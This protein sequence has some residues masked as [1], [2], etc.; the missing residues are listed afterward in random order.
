M[1]PSLFPTQ[2][3]YTPTSARIIDQHLLEQKG[4][5]GDEL[6]E[7]AGLSAFLIFKHIYPKAS[8][9]SVVTGG[10]NNAGDGF[11]LARLAHKEGL[12][13]R[14]YPAI[15]PI[16]LRG[17]AANAFNKFIA[18]GGQILSFVPQDFEGTEILIDAIFGS[19]LNRV[20]DEPISSI[21]NAINRYR[22]NCSKAQS[23][24]RA[25][26]SLDIPSGL[27]GATGSI[28]GV[29][30]KAD[31]TIS[32]ITQKQGLYTGEGPQNSGEIYLSR[33]LDNDSE[34]PSA[35]R[36]TAKIYRPPPLILPVR[37]RTAHK[38][39]FGHV[40]VIGG[41]EGMSG[42][43]LISALAALRSG[44]G[45]VS[46]ATKS[47]HSGALA[48]GHPEIMAHGAEDT[49][50]LIQLIRRATVLAIGPGL[51]L[52]TWGQRTFE[53]A[54]SSPLPKVIDADALN[55]LSASPRKLDNAILTPHP[56]EAARLLG[57]TAQEVQA[58]RFSAI[59]ELHHRFGSTIILKGSGSLFFDGFGVPKVFRVG[60]PGMASGGMGD[61]LTGL[62]AGLLAQGLSLGEA[63]QLSTYVH[64]LAGDIMAAKQGEIG[65]IATDLLPAI[66]SILNNQPPVLDS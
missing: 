55:W 53:H 65:L 49:E 45:L 56:G 2:N 30:V 63:A 44:S 5:S 29:S 61:L 19:G 43:P 21:I 66:R 10:G 42:A 20:I 39:R 58:D 9:L 1:K 15:D 11:V 62:I 64:G 38:G 25:I 59:R 13:V 47:T 8:T 46:I 12:D 7:R 24:E 50:T 22:W 28:L 32:F 41:E 60:N 36:P 37:S 34:L 4:I 26:I 57:C 48:L 33:L 52:K 23:K 27:D 16:M 17:D 6:M 51:G 35:V 3:L 40:L 31:V 18:L 54:I 14:V